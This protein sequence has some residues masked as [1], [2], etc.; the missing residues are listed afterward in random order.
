MR[1]FMVITVLFL[2]VAGGY[3]LPIDRE[4]SFLAQNFFQNFSG[5]LGTFEKLG[6]PESISVA[7]VHVASDRVDSF[8]S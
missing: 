6:A 1:I 3:I 8:L 2:R 4:G 5:Q 7:Y